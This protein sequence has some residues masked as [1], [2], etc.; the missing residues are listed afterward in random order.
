MATVLDHYSDLLVV[1]GSKVILKHDDRTAVGYLWVEDSTKVLIVQPHHPGS[2]K[3]HDR[4][5]TIPFDAEIK[6]IIVT[7]A[8]I[9]AV[10]E[11]VS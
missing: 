6:L 7:M 1:E 11:W 8:D 10:I 3:P 4:P 2:V 9:E 5:M